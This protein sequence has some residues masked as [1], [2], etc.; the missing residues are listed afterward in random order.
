MQQLVALRQEFR[1]RLLPLLGEAQQAAGADLLR[2]LEESPGSEVADALANVG[3]LRRDALRHERLWQ[4]RIDAAF[5][6]WPARAPTAAGNP[7][8]FALVSEGEL[9]TQLIG[10]PAIEALQRRFADALSVVESRLL[11]LAARMGGDGLPANPFAPPVVVDAFLVAFP[12]R[13]CEPLLRQIMLRHYERL[14]GAHLGATYAW[15][16]GALADGGYA[17][18][19]GSVHAAMA[20]QAVDTA[21]GASWRARDGLAPRA[22]GRQGASAGAQPDVPGVRG[23]RMRARVQA[24]RAPRPG[25][26]GRRP[27]GEREFL[28]VLSLLQGSETPSRWP[29]ADPAPFAVQLRRALLSGA[30]SLGMGVDAATPSPEQHDAIDITAALFDA[31][32]DAAI[33]TPDAQARLARLA[34]PWVRLVLDDA[35]L[36]DTAAHPAMRAL[37]AIITLWDGNPGVGEDAPLHAL[38]DAAADGIANGY[39]GDAALF[40]TTLAE[41]EAGSAPMLRRAAI[42]ERR[43]WQ[44]LEGGERLDAARRSADRALQA[45]VGGRAVLPVTAEFLAGPWRAA[46]VQAWLRDGAGSDRFAQLLALGDGVVQLDAD[47]AHAGGRSVADGAVAL[48]GPLRECLAAGGVDP[49]AVAPTLAALAAGLARPDAERTVPAPDP[50]ASGDAP[51]GAHA[52]VDPAAPGA[53]VQPGQVVV[54]REDGSGAPRHLRLAWRSALSGRCLLVTRQGAR[55]LLL[56]ASEFDDALARGA[57]VARAGADPVEAAVAKVLGAGD[58]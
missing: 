7:A 37:A 11:T 19:G 15:L 42:G 49:G 13:D 1:A 27:F 51:A 14:C 22:P 30:A 43:A 9:S 33:L 35:Q 41:L 23:Q 10:Q 55:H 38:A 6:G 44:A 2:M 20:S 26:D 24:R 4:A 50:L 56:S 12:P 45:R 40:A 28:A 3:M 8:S 5:A 58:G 17:M 57:L 18:L 29:P 47:A 46:L 34:W 52:P 54:A 48:E 53:L 16:N 36:F 31:L 39:Q 32:R 25:G 21:D